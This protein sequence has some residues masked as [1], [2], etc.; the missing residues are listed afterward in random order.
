MQ[1][2]I[3]VGGSS[4]KRVIN[5]PGS[6]QLVKKAP[7]QPPSKYAD[8]GTRLHSLV[9]QLVDGPGRIGDFDVTP[10]QAQKLDYCLRV[11]DDLDQCRSLTFDT[12]VRLAYDRVPGVFGT[13]DLIGT[14]NNGDT[15]LVL[16]WKFGDGVMVDA[17]ENDQLLFYALLAWRSNHWAFE[18]ATEIELVIV[19]PPK[20][21]RWVTSIRR[22]MRFEEDLLNA[23]RLAE[24]P[25][26]PTSIGE[27]CRF[28]P[29]KVI[30]PQQTGEIER[31]VRSELQ[32]LSP[33]QLARALELS[34]KLESFISAARALAQQ[35]LEAGLTVPGWKLVPKQARRTWTNESDAWAAL[36]AAGAPESELKE[37]R[38]VAQI[39]KVLK[40][41]KI[42]LPADV[43][44][45]VSS[46]DT[47]APESDPRPAKVLLGQQMAAALS[48]II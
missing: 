41:H 20:Y 7:P 26:P 13:V 34:D 29:A 31:V 27:W 24:L 36:I 37:L 28:C 38:S 25:T 8:E 1:Y 6:V 2:S 22:L 19:Q 39:E 40:K 30:C 42:A 9:D 47:I 5:C 12:E 23:L 33:E 3:L 46:G 11:L 45:S 35:T 16:D 18:K 10:E 17:E 14:N 32:K 4:A 15:A 48:K 44:T 21:R 43:V